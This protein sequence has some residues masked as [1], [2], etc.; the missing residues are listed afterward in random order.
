MILAANRDER[1]DRP[2]DPPASWWP[3]QPDV[4]GGRDRSAG[5]TWM[6]VNG[7]GVVACVLNRPGSL[8]PEPGKRSRGVLPRLALAQ[9]TLAAAVD[10]IMHIAWE[11]FRSFNLVLAD[12]EGAIFQRASGAGPVET[13]PLSPGVHM[14]T[15]HDPDDPESP[16]VARHLP[17]FR[18]APPPDPASGAWDSWTE[19][20]ADRSGPPGSE[21]NVPERAGFG[22]VCASLLAIPRAGAPIWL[23]AAGPPDR[24]A[25][26][27]VSL[28]RVSPRPV[29]PRPV[30][31]R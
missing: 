28:S 8:G 14:I 17:R 15:A 30:N 5:G 18:A 6:A 31:P 13:F 22:T 9:T 1:T 25:F 26:A 10:A 12:A 21:I 23:F 4:V 20:L 19:I 24:S 29:N 2:W 27:P 3:D 16:R 7:A 11:E